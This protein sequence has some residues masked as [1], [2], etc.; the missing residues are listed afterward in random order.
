MTALADDTN[1]TNTDT[2]TA[3]VTSKIHDITT[4]PQFGGLQMMDQV[5]QGFMGGH[6]GEGHG[7][8]GAKGDSISNIEISSEYKATVNALL[9]NDTDVT[10]L[11]SEGYN[12][13]SIHPI[14]KTVITG[15][16]TVATQATTAIVIMTNGTSG[17]ATVNVDIANSKVTYIT[18]ITKTVIDKSTS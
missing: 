12:E 4:L 13:T 1:S 11:V 16:G 10:N 8:H 18:I 9:E 6:G 3:A 5:G 14:I 7:M 15:D 17:Y 2:S